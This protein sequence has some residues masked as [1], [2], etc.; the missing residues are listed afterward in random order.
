MTDLPRFMLKPFREGYGFTLGR[1]TVS[2]NTKSGRSRQ[3]LDR[4]GTPHRL[5]ATYK[6]TPLMWQYLTAFLRKYEAKPFLAYLLLDDTEH[7]W[8]QCQCLDDDGIPVTTNGDQTF[9]AQLTLEALPMPV[10]STADSRNIQAYD[11]TG[12]KPSIWFKLLE[13]LANFQLP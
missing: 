11:M 2:T 1:N 9:T 4:I 8:Y 3:R 5:N 6:C 7:R 12:G 10:D 13:N